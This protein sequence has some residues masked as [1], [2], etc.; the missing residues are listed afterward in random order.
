MISA[1]LHLHPVAAYS[2]T[3]QLPAGVLCVP[4]VL[5][6][7]ESEAR[8]A[9]S[10]PNVSDTADPRESILYVKLVGVV[11]KSSNI[12]LAIRVHTAPHGRTVSI[13]L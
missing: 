2:G 4:L 11:W 13:F 9:T 8:R 5:H 12:D 7:E 6:L 10:H 3:I 1:H